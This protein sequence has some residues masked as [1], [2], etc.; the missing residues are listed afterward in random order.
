MFEK[1]R[2]SWARTGVVSGSTL[3]TAAATMSPGKRGN[4]GGVGC[5]LTDVETVVVSRVNESA[6]EDGGKAEESSHDWYPQGYNGWRKESGNRMRGLPTVKEFGDGFGTHVAHVF[7][8]ARL[9]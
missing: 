8:F 1:K 6:V 3:I 2:E 7:K 9:L 4:H 5:G